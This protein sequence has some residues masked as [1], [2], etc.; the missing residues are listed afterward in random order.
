[1]EYK[2]VCSDLDGTLINSNSE[3]SN[4]N[5]WAIDRL[6]E[7]GIYFVPATGRS[8]SEVPE[9]LRMNHSI[10]YYITSNGADIYDCHA[11]KHYLTCIS[12]QEMQRIM[13][14]LRAYDIHLT[15]RQ[16]GNFYVDAEL[17]KEEHY[18]YYNI[19]EA[20]CSCI[21]NF[22]ININGF[23]DFCYKANDVEALDLYFHQKE[24]IIVCKKELEQFAELRVVK[25]GEY[26]LEVMNVNAG[27]G[28]ALQTLAGM[29]DI[30]CANTIGVGDSE[31]DIGMI[32]KAGRGFA[33]S[34]AC[35]ELK[36][37]ADEVICSNDEHAIE[38]VLSHTLTLFS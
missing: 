11:D 23:K 38:Y 7:K 33:V 34:N 9:V 28:R 10:H 36:N 30:P 14:V 29:L 35:D 4:E 15:M 16:N 6:N 22:A 1:M 12:N 19:C 2:I 27:K 24:Q 31:N 21:D 17:T 5:L 13:D 32:E 3:I 20:H 37:I 25:V 26:S 8:Y 18:N